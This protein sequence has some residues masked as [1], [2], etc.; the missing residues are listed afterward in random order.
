VLLINSQAWFTSS[1][2]KRGE[3][4][5]DLSF[6]G[7]STPKSMTVKRL[8]VPHADDTAGLTWG[9]Q[10]YETSDG[11]VAGTLNTTSIPTASGVDIKDTEVVMLAF[12]Q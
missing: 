12:V 11:R 4:H 10:T 7:S 9:G 2:G 3:T 8:S 5:V 1:T 6:I